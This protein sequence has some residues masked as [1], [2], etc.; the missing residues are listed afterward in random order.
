MKCY[1]AG[2]M[3]GVEEYNYPEF[4]RVAKVLRDIGYEVFNPAEMDIAKDSEDYTVL[5]I[6][7]QNQTD[8]PARRRK[9]ARR[10]L[11]VLLYELRAEDGDILMTL[12]NWEFSGGANAEVAV[13]H[14]V[15][16]PV[17]DEQEAINYAQAR[18][19][20]QGNN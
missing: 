17:M 3:R 10:D 6:D 5:T 7:Q 13:A 15:S 1:I 2:P 12:E 8:S 4:M 9:F 16:L 19:E 18:L 20:E 14:W 11:E